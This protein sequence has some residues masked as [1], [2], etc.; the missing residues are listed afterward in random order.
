MASTSAP[1]QG[2]LPT[3]VIPQIGSLDSTQVAQILRNLPG[4]LNKVR[5]NDLPPTFLAFFAVCDVCGERDLRVEF[6]SK[7]W[8]GCSDHSELHVIHFWDEPS[9]PIFPILPRR[10]S[11]PLWLSRADDLIID[12]LKVMQHR[13]FLVWRNNNPG[14]TTYLNTN[15]AP[16]RVATP[17]HLLTPEDH[18][19]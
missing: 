3:E 5:D 9:A 18:R 13:S 19:T 11:F 1:Q 2:N 10:F 8:K 6:H 16:S 17:D 14:S 4:L 12:S 15:L 7:G